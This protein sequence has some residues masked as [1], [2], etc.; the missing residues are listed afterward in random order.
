MRFVAMMMFGDSLQVDLC[1]H[2]QGHEHNTVD[3]ILAIL[4]AVLHIADIE[5]VPDEATDGVC[6]KNE[7]VLA[8]G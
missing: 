6:I 3:G 4:A 5:F 8:L 1:W 7:N 2:V